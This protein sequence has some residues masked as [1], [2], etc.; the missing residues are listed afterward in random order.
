MSVS[1]RIN[2]LYNFIYYLFIKIVIIYIE[3]YFSYFTSQLFTTKILK[4]KL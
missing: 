3:K 4:T 1:V 2:T